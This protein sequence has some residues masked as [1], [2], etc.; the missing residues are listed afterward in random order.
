MI[1]GIALKKAGEALRLER[2]I[3]RLASTHWNQFI[4]RLDINVR[5]IVDDQATVVLRERFV[6]VLLGSVTSENLRRLRT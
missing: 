3:T 2:E 5:F 6:S 4:F 1:S